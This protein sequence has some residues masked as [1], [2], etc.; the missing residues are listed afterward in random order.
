MYRGLARLVGMTVLPVPKD[1]EE[2]WQQLKEN[3]DDYDFFFLHFK[4]TDSYGEDGNF[5]AKVKVIETVDEW[6]ARLREINPEVLVV[7]GDHSTPS[8]LKSH[9]WH[10]VPALLWSSKGLARQDSVM[11]FGEQTCI[12]GNIGRMP[13][14]NIL[15]IAMANA[16]RFK[17]FGA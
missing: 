15:L 16:E 2:M 6:S 13:M 12:Q 4:K 1:F 9:S 3:Y 11:Q 10:P 7:T 14:K 5:D 8:L 17:K